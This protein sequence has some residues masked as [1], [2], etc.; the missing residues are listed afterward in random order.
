MLATAAEP[1]WHL[2][3]RLLS[4]D[5]RLELRR[6]PDDSVVCRT[7]CGVVVNFNPGDQFMLKGSGIVPSGPLFF[8][9]RDGEVTL[10]AHPKSILWWILGGAAFAG[11]DYLVFR[12]GLS[13]FFEAAW[14][15]VNCDGYQDCIDRHAQNRRD[16]RVML[17]TGAGLFAAGALLFVLNLRTTWDVVSP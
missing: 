14:G 12:G 5:D 11:G 17:L 2:K 7:P 9:P 6:L 10:Q 1:Q 3:V 4:E 15:T 8:H 13:L 16:D